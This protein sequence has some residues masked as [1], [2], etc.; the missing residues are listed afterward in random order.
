[1]SVS[2]R[3]A[4][5]SASARPPRQA[6]ET[7]KRAYLDTIGVT[8]AGSAEPS[9]RLVRDLV[10][11]ESPSG[12][13][14]ILGTSRCAGAIGAAL[15][16]GT[17]AHALDFD[18]VSVVS[19]AHP[20]ASLVPATLAASELV[21]GDGAALLDAYCVGFEVAAILGRA[22]NPAHYVR[23]WHCTSTIGT[24]GAA[25]AAA[26]VLGLDAGATARCLGIAASE[27]SG[28]KANFG[29]MT[30]PLHAGFA[31][32]NGVLA[33]KLAAD[34]F[35]ASDAALDGAQGFA[36]AFG[37]ESRD[38]V[39]FMEQIGTRWELVETGIIVK[40]Y[41]SCAGTHPTLDALL[42]LRRE[43]GFTAEEI[44]A[45]DVGVDAVTPT[46]LQYDQPRTGLEAK[47]SLPYCA[48]AAILD[49]A[50]GLETFEDGRVARPA[51]RR[52][53]RL[54]TMRIEPEL[55]PSAAPL[56]QAIV[57]V[58]LHDGRELRR[59]IRGARGYPDC[60]ASQGE[61]EAK[62]CGCAERVLPAAAVEQALETFRGLQQL[63]SVRMLTALLHPDEAAHSSGPARQ[64]L[65]AP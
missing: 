3:I 48:A 50:V 6:I 17:A 11:G 41:P 7:A 16:N 4:E 24:I 27:A 49:G 29:T 60:P 9:A 33:A 5:F 42:D 25:A 19:L 32:R 28:L 36:A 14:S 8:L 45:V 44:A 30:K 58:R 20:S 37:G 35:G 22:L 15:A 39:P 65:I 62:F 1:M 59:A 55:D 64:R 26:R 54:V 21:N 47:F 57:V 23:G 53:L 13:A 10:A 61:L 2:R 34:G 46:V 43:E 63:S 40:L 12:P 56:T 31:A 52:L 38:L 18:D 51:V